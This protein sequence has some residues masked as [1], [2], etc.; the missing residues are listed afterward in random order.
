MIIILLILPL[1]VKAG[2]LPI[3]RSGTIYENGDNQLDFYEYSFYKISIPDGV[4]FRAEINCTS[5]AIL[6]VVYGNIT[7][8][9][10]ILAVRDGKGTNNQVISSFI[11]SNGS[12][13]MDFIARSALSQ[14]LVII[15]YYNTNPF[16]IEYTLFSNIGPKYENLLSWLLIVGII[17]YILLTKKKTKTERFLVSQRRIN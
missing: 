17:S 8:R 9:E 6:L 7:S 4:H 5:D 3:I 15:S 2:D 10:D 13:S 11:T 1:S 16:S 14:H 12:G